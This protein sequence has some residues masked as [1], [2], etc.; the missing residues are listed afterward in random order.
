M[1]KE[2]DG[3]KQIDF[4][5]SVIIPVFIPTCGWIRTLQGTVKGILN[6]IS[7]LHFIIKLSD[8][9]NVISHKRTI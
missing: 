5:V 2:I 1:D 3:G 4:L 9:F 7:K 8:S 6:P